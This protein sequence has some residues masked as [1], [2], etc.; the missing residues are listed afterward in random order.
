MMSVQ[1]KEMV[2][3]PIAQPLKNAFARSRQGE[4]WFHQSD[5]RE[6]LYQSIH[7][8]AQGDFHWEVD[9]LGRESVSEAIN[10]P[11]SVTWSP[12][13]AWVSAW[14]ALYT[15]APRRQF[16]YAGQPVS[17]DV[18]AW[19]DNQYAL[20][21]VDE[22]LR[23]TDMWLRLYGNVLLRPL[24]H[25]GQLVLHVVRPP[26]YRVV[27]DPLDPS[28]PLVT[29][30]LG[31]ADDA[32]HSADVITHDG[33]VGYYDGRMD[34]IEHPD[35]DRLVVHCADRVQTTSD[36]Y[37]VRPVG[38]QLANLIV[39]I[40]NDYIDQLGYNLAMQGHGQLVITGPGIKTSDMQIGPGHALQLGEGGTAG[41]ISPNAPIAQWRDTIMMLVSMAREQA[42]IPEAMLHARASAS[43]AAIVAANAPIA[44]V[45]AQRELVFSGIERRLLHSILAAS[46]GEAPFAVGALSEWEI[47]ITY[48][49]PTLAVMQSDLAREQW[50]YDI[51]VQDEADIMMREQPTHYATR[52][53][54]LDDFAARNADRAKAVAQ[55]NEQTTVAEAEASAEAGREIAAEEQDNADRLAED[56]GSQAE[57][58]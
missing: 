26:Y 12:L 42:S 38:L 46:G 25:R 50:L 57:A 53:Q 21:R 2:S 52:Q 5:T 27:E 7:S 4:F 23:M 19:I 1:L 39:R 16:L 40:K 30:I 29:V 44:E 15:Y 32:E 8:I 54:A 45:R 18:S 6:Q 55:A 10:R 24:W 36:G 48:D 47:D 51:G 33:M 14:S 31:R 49:D 41:F 17:E 34:W 20:A 35:S 58:G 3:T 13:T 43:G 11:G 37:W 9:P 28:R 22:S 56:R